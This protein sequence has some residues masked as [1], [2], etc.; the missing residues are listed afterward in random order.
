MKKLI[1]LSGLM[2]LVVGCSSKENTEDPNEET[3][4]TVLQHTFTGPNEKLQNI[5]GQLYN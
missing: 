3:I 5:W 4:E 1:L 2:F